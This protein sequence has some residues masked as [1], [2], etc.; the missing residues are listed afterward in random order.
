MVILQKL[1]IFPSVLIPVADMLQG[2]LIPVLMANLWLQC[3]LSSLVVFL[4]LTIFS[5]LCWSLLHKSV[6]LESEAV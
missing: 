2:H 1:E 6:S 3:L 4:A 5:A